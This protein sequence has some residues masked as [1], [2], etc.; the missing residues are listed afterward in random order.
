MEIKRI[1]LGNYFTNCY[2]LSGGTAGQAVLIDPADD[3][4]GLVRLLKKLGL[5]PAAILLTHGHYDHI[6]AVPNLQTQWPELPVYCHPLDV[7]KELVE[8]DMGQTYPTVAAFK[9]L[10]PLAEGQQLALGG[11][12]I[13]VMH[14]PGHTP[15][16]V[17]FEIGNNLFT[18]DTLFRRSI[19]R[20]DFA[21]G[22]DA[23]MAQSLKR[24]ASITANYNVYPGHEEP[25]TLAEE[26]Q[27]NPYLYL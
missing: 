24:L 19:G 27:Q 2:L 4:P 13:G 18:G 16:S 3:G 21:G 14:T 11:F 20:T 7:P 22:N 8:H 15:G 10:L 1:E 12:T 26:Q 5:T 17:I 25:T 9:N 6:L 23:Q